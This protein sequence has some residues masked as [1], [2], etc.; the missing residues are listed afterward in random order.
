VTIGRRLE[1]G[2]LVGAGLVTLALVVPLGVLVRDGWVPLRDADTRASDALSLPDGGA[3]EAVIML[4]QLGA[5]LLLEAAALLLAFFLVRRKRARLAAYVGLTV[6]G[7]QVLSFGTKLVVERVRPCDGLD[8]CP[9]T[10]SFPSGHAVGSAAFWTAVAVVLLPL[11][12]R[13]A[14]VLLVIPPVVA[15]SRV[16]LGVH[17]P[18]DVTAGLL[19][20]GC[21]AAACTA[22]FSAWRAQD[23]GHEVPLEE[24]MDDVGEREQS[25]RTR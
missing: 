2:L 7:A 21:W 16:L 22:V 24:G 4:T 11:I 25:A 14:W 23:V 12:G 6:F 19:M 15:L 13:R 9:I 20:G 8:S 5:P 10:T 18:S 17:Y 1:H 3:R